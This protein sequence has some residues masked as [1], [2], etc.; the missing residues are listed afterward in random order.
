MACCQS[1][2]GIQFTITTIDAEL[3]EPADHQASRC[4][5]VSALDVVSSAEGH[6]MPRGRTATTKGPTE[7]SAETKRGTRLD[8]VAI[9]V[10]AVATVAAFRPVLTNQFVNWDD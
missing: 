9:I 2:L 1:R 7:V 4:S 5:A 6:R 10:I 8:L 3:A